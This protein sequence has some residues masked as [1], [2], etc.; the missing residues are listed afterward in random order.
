MISQIAYS[1]TLC[2]SKNRKHEKTGKEDQRL[3]PGSELS[4]RLLQIV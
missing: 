1:A 4:S 3:I 2:E